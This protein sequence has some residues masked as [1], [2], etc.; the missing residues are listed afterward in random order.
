MP[1]QFVYYFILLVFPQI[2]LSLIF[3]SPSHPPR[4]EKSPRHR[5]DIQSSLVILLEDA[6]STTSCLGRSLC[7]KSN[8][9]QR[10]LKFEGRAVVNTDLEE[11][12]MKSW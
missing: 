3:S 6:S 1:E 9:S 11:V 12:C 7:T 5:I 8:I 2:C 4:P 10:R